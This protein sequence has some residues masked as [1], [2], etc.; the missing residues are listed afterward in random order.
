MKKE[1]N[2]AITISIVVVVVL[3]VGYL[4]FVRSDT[5]STSGEVVHKK[6]ETSVPADK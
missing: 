4:L 5:G 6:N 1:I 2:P 3:I